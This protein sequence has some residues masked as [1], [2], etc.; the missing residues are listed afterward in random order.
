MKVAAFVEPLF[1]FGVVTVASPSP[2]PRPTLDVGSIEQA[3]ATF[4]QRIDLLQQNLAQQNKLATLG[5]VTAVIA[6]EFNN[7]LTPMVAYTKFALSAKADDA[8]REKAL[9]KAMTGAER[10]ANISQSLLGFSRG[11]ESSSAEV[12]T[13]V[14]ETL[15]CLSR[16]LS[17]DGISLTLD[18]PEGLRVAMNGGYL[19]QVLMNLIVNARSAMLG[20]GGGGAGKGGGV[21]RLTVRATLLTGGKMAAITVA[22]SG[23]GIPAEV[24][25]RIF[26]PFFSTKRGAEAPPANVAKEAEPTATETVPRGGTGLGLT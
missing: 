9:T 10:L 11:D 24:L 17:K 8:L 5:M 6:H 16:D 1:H 15:V 25:P 21:K 3:L 18:V 4:Q 2:Q 26:D 13:A 22:D 7:I 14:K 23:P 12:L 19:Q 20:G